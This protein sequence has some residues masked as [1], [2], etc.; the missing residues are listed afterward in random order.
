MRRGAVGL[1]RVVVVGE[2]TYVKISVF[3]KEGRE[4]GARLWKRGESA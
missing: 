4:R 3:E 2:A 1:D